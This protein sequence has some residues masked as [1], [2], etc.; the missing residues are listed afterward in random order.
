MATLDETL[1][2]ATHVKQKNVEV[3]QL[4]RCNACLRHRRV[5]RAI[6]PCLAP[7]QRRQKLGIETC[8]VVAQRVACHRRL[9]RP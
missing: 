8:I 9:M 2:V 6:P 3:S 7:R 5:G 4:L 1:A